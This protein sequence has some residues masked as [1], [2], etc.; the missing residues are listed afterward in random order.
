MATSNYAGTQPYAGKA[1]DGTNINAGEFGAYT[2]ARNNRGVIRCNGTVNSGVVTSVKTVRP[3]V[4][5]FGSTVI[6][7]SV[8]EK[9]YAGKAISG[10]TFAH[11]HVKP[12]SSLITTEIAGVS[13][14]VIKSPGNDGDTIR[15]INSLVTLRTR[16]FT[17]AI[18]ANKY[19]RVTG[20]FDGGFPVVATDSL[21]SDTAAAVT[22][23]SPGKLV[24][25]TG[26][27][28]PTSQNYSAKTN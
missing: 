27:K 6:E 24:F 3:V 26:K 18:R 10:G 14:N 21:A 8:T 4:T 22:R 19:N 13:T 11:N 17:T 1:T 9:D 23:S 20:E 7:N 2:T 25:L 28:T 5:T 15:S 16:R 12:I